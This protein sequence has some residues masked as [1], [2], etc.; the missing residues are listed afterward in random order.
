MS[1][2]SSSNEIHIQESQG[3]DTEHLVDISCGQAYS[4][5]PNAWNSEI[6]SEVG[7]LLEIPLSSDERDDRSMESQQEN[8]EA[9]D[10]DMSQSE[11][12]N[13]NI[14]PEAQTQMSDDWSLTPT[15]QRN[16]DYYEPEPMTQDDDLIN[17]LHNYEKSF[18]EW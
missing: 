17:A 16:Y 14:I 5:Q 6:D 1:D 4:N 12:H 2:Q 13:P 9:S 8:V 18:G 10:S 3:F 15:D 11:Y 7:G